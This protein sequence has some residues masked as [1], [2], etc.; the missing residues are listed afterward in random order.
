MRSTASSKTG[1]SPPPFFNT[2]NDS[3][4]SSKAHEGNV[5]F[6][7]TST[8]RLAPIC[9]SRPPTSAHNPTSLRGEGSVEFELDYMPLK[10][11]FATL[12]GLRVIQVGDDEVDDP[13]L[14]D[15]PDG[16]E[17]RTLREWD[18]IGEV[19]VQDG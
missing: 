5:V 2:T 11:G 8:L 4:G 13:Q 16:R 15:S 12:G 7:G 3:D 18:V 1:R 17:M 9:I 10:P 14:A 19:W 6:L